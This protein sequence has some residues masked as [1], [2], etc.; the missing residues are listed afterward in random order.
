MSALNKEFLT[1]LV[2]A[3]ETIEAE[4]GYIPHHLLPVLPKLIKLTED[5][6]ATDQELGNFAIWSSLIKD[7]E[8]KAYLKK[9]YGDTYDR[10]PVMMLNTLNS[11]LIYRNA[12]F[13][14]RVG[15]ILLNESDFSL[16]SELFHWLKWDVSIN[17]GHDFL[18]L[19]KMAELTYPLLMLEKSTSEWVV[20]YRK[21]YQDFL[22]IKGR[23]RAARKVGIFKQLAE[24]LALIKA[25]QKSD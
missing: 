16:L 11:E 24:F 12:D 14:N 9:H 2:K 6:L 20:D 22:A 10:E 4:S 13:L 17:S 25:E 8:I 7:K 19:L 1:G 3:T 18:K 21:I 5:L 15:P 23:I